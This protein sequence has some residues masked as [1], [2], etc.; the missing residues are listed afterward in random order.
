M[1][2]VRV[3][4]PVVLDRGFVEQGD[5]YISKAFDNRVG[6][7][8]VLETMKRLRA[9]AVDVYA[10]GS[11]Q[12]EVGIRGMKRAAQ[13]VTPD[14]GVAVDVTAAFDT[15]GVPDHEQVTTLGGGTAIK[16]NDQA[17]ISN[18]G[19]VEFMK[20]LAVKHKIKH[21]LEVLPFGGTDAGGMQLFGDGAVCTLSVPTRYV[22]SPSEIIHKG[23]LRAS[24]DLLVKFLESA[25]HCKPV[26]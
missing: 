23:D 21:Q 24:I 12:E 9:H 11:S 6:C 17:T 18:H 7:Y 8:V 16:I 4:D 19:V 22:H 20:K 5:C 3:G 1:K 25:E 2:W 10:V 15:P 26:F 13:S 14:I